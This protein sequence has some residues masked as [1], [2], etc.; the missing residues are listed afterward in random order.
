[1][2]NRFRIKN[3]LCPIENTDAAFKN[4]VDNLFNNAIIIKNTLDIDFNDKKL[5]IVKFVKI[6][7]STRCC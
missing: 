2:K 5:E 6:F 3:L 1:M 7:L 4:F